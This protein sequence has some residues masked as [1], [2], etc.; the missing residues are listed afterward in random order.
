MPDGLRA[1][2]VL[3]VTAVTDVT[4]SVR[5]V[6]L[7]G[8]PDAVGAAAGGVASMRGM[9]DNSL[10]R[11]DPAD[12]GGMGSTGPAIADG[13]ASLSVFGFTVL[14]SQNGVALSV[15]QDAT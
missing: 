7:A 13:A 9:A 1:V 15:G 8:H 5:R 10:E 3:T 12:P 2:H 6:L 4:P 14:S 11:A